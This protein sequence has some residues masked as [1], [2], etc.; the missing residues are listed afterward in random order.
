MLAAAAELQ[1]KAAVVEDALIQI[2]LKT[3]KD[4][5]KFPIKLS[6]QLA[7][8]ESIVEERGLASHEAKLRGISGFE[9][10]S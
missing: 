2:K 7:E 3:L 6:G 1:K 10:K 5:I 4:L 8:L 9:R